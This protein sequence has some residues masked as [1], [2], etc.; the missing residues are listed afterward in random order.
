MSGSRRAGREHI[1]N[2]MIDTAMFRFV[3]ANRENDVAETRPRLE[4]PVVDSDLECR[5]IFVPARVDLFQI[6]GV[7][8]DRLFLEV[9]HDTVCGCR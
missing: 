3:I 8:D 9:T 4:V 2:L 1:G 6:V 5:H 7:T